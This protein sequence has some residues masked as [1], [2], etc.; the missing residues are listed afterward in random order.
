MHK[1]PCKTSAAADQNKR[2]SSFKKAPQQREN[3]QAGN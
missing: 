3:L 1:K 2:R